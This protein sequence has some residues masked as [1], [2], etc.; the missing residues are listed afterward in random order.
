MGDP[1]RYTELDRSIVYEVA[2][3]RLSNLRALAPVFGKFL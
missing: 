2:T 1:F 3:E